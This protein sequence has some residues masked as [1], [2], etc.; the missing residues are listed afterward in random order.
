[1]SVQNTSPWVSPPSVA[2]RYP[3]LREDEHGRPTC[4]PNAL[5]PRHPTHQRAPHRASARALRSRAAG[6]TPR[7]PSQTTGCAIPRASRP[8]PPLLE[9]ATRPTKS[10]F[11][12]EPRFYTSFHT[13]SIIEILFCCLSPVRS[14]V[15]V[16]RGCIP[17]LG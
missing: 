16:I 6:R 14:Y 2:T 4:A 15:R 10:P 9:I 17:G 3:S 7:P 1:M 13:S 12:R 5:S 11:S 8:T